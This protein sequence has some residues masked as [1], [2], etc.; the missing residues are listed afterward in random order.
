MSA[1]GGTVAKVAQCAL[2][3]GAAQ[4]AAAVDLK[5][6]LL[7]NIRDQRSIVDRI[8][9]WGDVLVARVADYKRDVA[10]ERIADHGQRQQCGKSCDKS[11]A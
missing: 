3:I 9:K 5:T 7:E 1:V 8:G 6:G 4:I 11:K 2:E 10:S